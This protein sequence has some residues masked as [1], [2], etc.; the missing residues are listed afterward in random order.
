MKSD[1]SSIAQGDLQELSPDV[2]QVRMLRELFARTR[3]SAIVGVPPVLLLGW[4][5]RDAQPIQYILYWAIAVF[6]ALS[7][8]FL[9]GHLYL[10]QPQLQAERR[11]VWFVLEW[12]G[13]VALAAVWV[14][15]ITLLGSGV[16]DA[17]FYLRL[18]RHLC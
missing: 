17:L 5:H 13:A 7:Y 2:V 16:V 4:A 3:E 10:S 6:F 8:R 14:S 1:A 15:S 11:R 12:V 18:W 9:V